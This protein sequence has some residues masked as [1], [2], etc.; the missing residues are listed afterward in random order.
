VQDPFLRPLLLSFA[1]EPAA[2]PQTQPLSVL[3]TRDEPANRSP[4]KQET[5]AAADHDLAPEPPATPPPQEQPVA[6]TEQPQVETTA[7]EPSVPPAAGAE[8]TPVALGNVR[9][10]RPATALKAPPGAAASVARPSSL[11]SGPQQS[12]QDEIVERFI[13]YDI[14]KL[15]GAA[16]M[17][18]RRD[19]E[20]LGPDAIPALVRGLNRSASIHATCPVCVLTSKLQSALSQNE[21]PSLFS[22]AASNIGRDVP[23]DAPHWGRLRSFLNS[24]KEPPETLIAALEGSDPQLRASAMERI[25]DRHGALG[26]GEK[27]LVAEALINLIQEDAALALAAHRVLAAM[28]AGQPGAPREAMLEQD[29]QAVAEQWRIH[30]QRVAQRERLKRAS[31]HELHS[32]LASADATTAFAA[33]WTIAQRQL[34]TSDGQRLVL[35]RD[36]IAML[37]ASDASTREIAH[38]ALVALAGKNPPRHGDVQQWTTWWN[39]MERDKLIAPRANAYLSMAQRLEARGDLD[40]AASRYGRIVNEF[41]STPAAR[42]ARERL[43]HLAASR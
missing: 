21:D 41:P 40:E 7:A 42:L 34:R 29:A 11:D 27:Q 32:A 8:D 30:W 10:P 37:A 43:A 18:A 17:L 23:E 28:T 15:T 33:A 19:F 25:V 13:L 16:G 36:L 9:S 39:E 26:P 6:A 4:A 14:G 1:T 20:S 3:V 5:D 31:P 2:T 24:L 22:Y 12:L 35:A 38:L